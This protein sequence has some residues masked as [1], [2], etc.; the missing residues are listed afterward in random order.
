LEYK[1]IGESEMT[2]MS[3][4]DALPEKDPG[5]KPAAHGTDT[6]AIMLNEVSRLRSEARSTRHAYW[7]PLVIFGL[8]IGGSAPFYIERAPSHSGFVS[9]SG[10]AIPGFSPLLGGQS[11]AFIYWLLAIGA[12]LYL[13]SLWY[14]R[15]GRMVGLVTQ[16]RG[17]VIA[18]VIVGALLLVLPTV[19]L[20]PGDLV[21]RGT[22]PFLIIAAALL[23]LARAE[24]SPALTVIAV[25]FTGTAL[26][27]S[28][29]NIENILFR[30]GWNPAGAQWRLTSL[31]NIFLPA[32]I[33]LV[34]GAGAYAVQRRQRVQA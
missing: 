33:L 13:T 2:A 15:H 22:L 25:V 30:L 11:D 1:A 4:A 12:G 27:A 29:Y 16:A 31:P 17:L 19:Q 23:V 14:G 21:I 34:S 28:L 10:A 3:P 24:R 32:L 9:A 18:G 20:L 26:L 5:S 6:P 7:L 8:V